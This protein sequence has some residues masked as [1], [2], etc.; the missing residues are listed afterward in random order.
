MKVSM[1][2]SN[3]KLAVL[4]LLVLLLAGCSVTPT[5]MES[6]QPVGNVT[7]PW[8]GTWVVSPGKYINWDGSPTLANFKLTNSGEKGVFKVEGNEYTLQQGQSATV[9]VLFS[10]DKTE[11][12]FQKLGQ[13]WIQGE[14]LCRI[15]KG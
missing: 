11:V 13:G 5:V 4:V 1:N 9:S 2:I 12:L 14:V 3:V 8:T 15:E 7:D 6:I 10:K